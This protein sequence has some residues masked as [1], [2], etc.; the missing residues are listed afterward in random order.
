M[1]P[2]VVSQE[3]LFFRW[4]FLAVCAR[5]HKCTYIRKEASKFSDKSRCLPALWD[6][7]LLL[8]FSKAARRLDTAVSGFEYNED[9][10]YVRDPLPVFQV[11]L[12][13]SSCTDWVCWVSNTS[14]H[15][16]S[17]LSIPW[18]TQ[19]R[20]VQ[21]KIAV[22]WGNGSER[23]HAHCLRIGVWLLVFLVYS[24]LPT[25]LSIH[26]YEWRRWWRVATG[27][28][29]DKEKTKWNLVWVWEWY[30]GE[31]ER[32]EKSM[33]WQ[34]KRYKVTPIIILHNFNLDQGY[35]SSH[36]LG[37]SLYVSWVVHEKRRLDWCRLGRVSFW[38]LWSKSQDVELLSACDTLWLFLLSSLCAST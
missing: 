11:A 26:E 24:I 2:E 9:N 27:V 38:H 17:I 36:N 31:K 15:T 19:I 12:C 14:F 1:I 20:C 33:N 28:H 30:R 16:I 4:S 22:G 25:L 10:N 35:V 7:R 32:R 3:L 34:E 8:R 18:S 13:I 29:N 37:S 23:Y 5:L 21:R 6:S